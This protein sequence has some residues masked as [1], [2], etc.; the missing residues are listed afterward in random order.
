MSRRLVV[1]EQQLRNAIAFLKRKSTQAS[2]RHLALLI[3]FRDQPHQSCSAIADSAGVSRT[4]MSHVVKWVN[5]EKFEQLARQGPF[6]RTALLTQ[7]Q[8]EDLARRLGKDLHNLQ[9]IRAWYGQDVST[10]TIYRWLKELGLRF[11]R[12]AKQVEAKKSSSR[13]RARRPVSRRQLSDQEVEELEHRVKLERQRMGLAATEL[14]KPSRRRKSRRETNP[15][16]RLSAIILVNATDLPISA[17]AEKLECY[18]ADVRRWQ[19]IYLEKGVEELCEDHV[20]GRGRRRGDHSSANIPGAHAPAVIHESARIMA[21]ELSFTNRDQVE[22]Y[23]KTYVHPALP[24]CQPNLALL[25]GMRGSGK[26]KLA[27]KTVTQAYRFNCEDINVRDDLLRADKIMRRLPEPVVV[28]DEIAQL[29]NPHECVEAAIAAGKTVLA[30]SSTRWLPP[31]KRLTALAEA[32]G[33]Y[34][35]LPMEW[36]DRLRRASE[37][38]LK[39]LSLEALVRPGLPGF[40]ADSESALTAYRDWARVVFER[41]VSGRYACEFPQ[42]ERVLEFTMARSGAILSSREIA[43]YCTLPSDTVRACQQ[44]LQD[45]GVIWL[46]PVL[47]ADSPNQSRIYA[48]DPGFMHQLESADTNTSHQ[49]LHLERLWRHLVLLRLRSAIRPANA[50]HA[51]KATDGMSVDFVVESR[52]GEWVAIQ[53]SWSQSDCVGGLRTF[54]KTRPKGPNFVVTPQL[55][56]PETHSFQGFEYTVCSLGS[57]PSV[58]CETGQIPRVIFSPVD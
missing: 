22:G 17:I 21:L 40:F 32:I 9:D 28:L 15:V 19:A 39:D 43:T 31:T 3:R 29:R 1:N 12:P 7:T 50:V 5:S 41:E 24:G 38:G 46:V 27:A 16:L 53:C 52:P 8:K 10:A 51:W 13:K 2:K 6:R 18:Q 14:R 56:G 37:A 35:L 42:F 4:H 55:S 57:F 25:N 20:G 48:L 11:P 45:T 34:E 23:L 30:I 44:A 49:L 33:G 54:R 58:N 26:T 47:G 36:E